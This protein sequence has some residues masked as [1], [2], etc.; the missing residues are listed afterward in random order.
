MTAQDDPHRILKNKS[1]TLQPI[2]QEEKTSLTD[3]IWCLVATKNRVT[4]VKHVNCH[5]KSNINWRQ[6]NILLQEEGIS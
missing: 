2:G 3:D 6:S 1:G 4:N 5:T